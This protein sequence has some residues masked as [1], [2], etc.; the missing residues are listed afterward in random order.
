MKRGV[1]LCFV[2]S[3]AGQKLCES[4]DSPCK[5]RKEVRWDLNSEL[6]VPEP[7]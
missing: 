6:L 1:V 5:N 7:A 4:Y 2:E 3:E